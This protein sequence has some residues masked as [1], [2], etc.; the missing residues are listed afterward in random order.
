MLFVS[1]VSGERGSVVIVAR[2]GGK[3]LASCRVT[4]IANRSLT[5]ALTSR[6]AVSPRGVVV[7][8]TLSR[9]GALRAT[10]SVTYGRLVTTDRSGM[11]T[12]SG[13]S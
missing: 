6:R 13:S 5:C 7:K 8:L 3:V 10:R 11:Q 1:A 12:W 9:D 4:A 2:K